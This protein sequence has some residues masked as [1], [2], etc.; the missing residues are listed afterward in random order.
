M[1]Q[2]FSYQS[3]FFSG[4]DDGELAQPHVV[5]EAAPGGVRRRGPASRAR[6]VPAGAGLRLGPFSES[7]MPSNHFIQKWL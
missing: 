1:E 2:K 4:V 7:V 5:L 3:R 6:A